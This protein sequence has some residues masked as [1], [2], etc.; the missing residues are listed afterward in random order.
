MMPMGRG[1]AELLPH[2]VGALLNRLH[3]DGNAV[4]PIDR[5]PCGHASTRLFVGVAQ[6]EDE[7][8]E[9]RCRRGELDPVIGATVDGSRR[10]NNTPLGA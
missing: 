3:L 5:S 6:L 9:C 10:A 1:H 7:C 8:V 2:G 4:E